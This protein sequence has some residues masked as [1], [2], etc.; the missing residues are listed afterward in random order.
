MKWTSISKSMGPM[1]LELIDYFFATDLKFRAVIVKKEQI[2]ESKVDFRYNDFY[3]QM[4]RELISDKL[5]ENFNYNIY[6]D[7][8][9]TRSQSKLKSLRE[10]LNVNNNIRCIQFIKSHESFLMQMADVIMGAINYRL[11]NEDKVIAKM[12]IIEKIEFH[13]DINLRELTHQAADKFNLY[14]IDLK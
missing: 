11:R 13:T 7:T 8:K 12:K 14:H 2:N 5:H 3:F 4:Y 6:L 10:L 1:Y 9:D